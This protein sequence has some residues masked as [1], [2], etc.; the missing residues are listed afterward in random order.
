MDKI[1]VKF[2][3]SNLKDIQGLKWILDRIQEYNRPLIIVV[4][5]F[6]GITNFLT[7]GLEQVQSQEDSIEELLNNIR[8]TK[9]EALDY[10]L[11]DSEQKESVKELLQTRMTQLGKYLRGIHYIGD[12]PDFVA[13]QVLSYGERLSSLILT[14]ILQSRNLSAKEALPEEIGLY[15]DGEYGNATV[16]FSKSTAPVQKALSGDYIYV[17]PGFYGIGQNGKVTLLGRGGSDYSAAALARMLKASSLDVWKD[18]QG[19]RTADPK[20]VPQ[21]QR[22]PTLTYQEA[23]EL[24]YFGAKILHPRTVEPL[25]SHNIPIRLFNIE[26]AGL[27]PR[28]IITDNQITTSHGVKSVTYSDDFSILRLEGP[29]IGVK[30]G[31]L[32]QITSLLDQNGINI[33]SVVTS[34]TV[35][36]LYLESRDLEE[37]LS[38]VEQSE[39]PSLTKVTGQKNLT[40]VAV[41]GQGIKDQPGLAMKMIAAL[42]DKNI[43]IQNIA[44]GASDTASYLVIARGDREEA[45]RAIHHRFFNN[46]EKE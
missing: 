16:D 35:I 40:I 11:E 29:G 20:M 4:S 44:L 24:S 1:V 27:N 15:T 26:E 3:G 43:N 31:I 34:Q 5:A 23:A 36:N 33:K 41:V 17:V 9:F 14:A 21:S 25:M 22:I 7:Q 18:V 42:S 8:N 30:H 39:N 46:P 37:A 13:D 19:Y 12:V 28:S 32:A 45:V 6:Y 2:G 38:L 10:F